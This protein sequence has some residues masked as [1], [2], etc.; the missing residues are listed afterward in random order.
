MAISHQC[1]SRLPAKYCEAIMGD[2]LL[3]TPSKGSHVA[4]LDLLKA[5]LKIGLK[6]LILKFTIHGL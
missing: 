3:F 1:N 2:L 4:K 6:I 5:L